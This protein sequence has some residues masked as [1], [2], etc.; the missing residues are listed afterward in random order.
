MSLEPRAEE[1]L[2]KYPD[3]LAEDELIE[4]RELAEGDFLLTAMMES[5]HEAGALLDG[6]GGAIE[7]SEGGRDLLD[8]VVAETLSEIPNA[9]MTLEDLMAPVVEGTSSKGVSEEASGDAMEHGP[10]ALEEVVPLQARKPARSGAAMWR[11]LAALVVLGAGYGIWTGMSTDQPGPE[12]APLTP[13]DGD[14]QTRG[15]QTPDLSGSP[16]S[17][18]AEAATAEE[19]PPAPVETAAA[20]RAQLLLLEGGVDDGMP[21]ISTGSQRSTTAPIRFDARVNEPRSLALLEAEAE[22]RTRVIY[23][24]AGARWDIGGEDAPRG[25]PEASAITP[26]KAGLASYI[27]VGQAPGQPFEIPG[28]GEVE[29]VEAF[30]V[31]HNAEVIDRLEIRWTEAE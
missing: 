10:T 15:V 11:A 27:L 20:S 29:S 31:G 22:G 13:G 6:G 2:S 16:A 7:M 21:P 28:D 4:L 26:Q 1:L 19:A 3:Q 12:N 9:G 8:S 18:E 14:L 24:P 25:V 5:I 30:I 23:P 17:H